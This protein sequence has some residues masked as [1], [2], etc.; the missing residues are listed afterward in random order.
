MALPARTASLLVLLLAFAAS[1]AEPVPVPGTRVS[2]VVPEGFALSQDFPG[3]GRDDDLTS[4]L[5][6]ELPVAVTIARQDLDADALAARGVR[7][8]RL[9]EVPVA[10][11]QG[12]LAHAT[13]DVA[14]VAF[15]KWILLFGDDTKSV[16]LT[17][18][19]PLDLEAV[20]GRALVDTLAGARWSPEA[21]AD[22][23]AALPFRVGEA[24]PLRILHSAPNAV[25]L[26][27]PD[28]TPDRVVPLVAVG[29]SLAQ[30]QIGDLPAFA[31]DRLMQTV[32][33]EEIEVEDERARSLDGMPGHQIEARARDAASEREV[34]VTQL[35]A[36]DGARYFLVHGIAD[37]A[38]GEAFRPLLERVIASFERVPRR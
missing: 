19:T 23:V 22:P 36:T 9:V 25:V 30:V 35:L 31:R 21:P 33:I 15:R 3:L 27:D 6:T 10:G 12:W 28:P 29:V 34:I 32:S 24:P 37:A 8:H 2:L 4:I 38:S 20:H 26:S 16:L 11:R 13:Q 5:V 14:G 17:A 1:A 18:T 7:V